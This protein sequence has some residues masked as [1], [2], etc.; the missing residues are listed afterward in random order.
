[1]FDALGRL[2]DTIF[3]EFRTLGIS[4]FAIGIIVMALLTAFGGEE[5]KRTFQRGFITCIAGII[6]FFLAKPII[7]FF[8][9]NL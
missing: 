1:M 3:T 2:V 8:Q 5:N 6:V 9:G 4:I 7:S